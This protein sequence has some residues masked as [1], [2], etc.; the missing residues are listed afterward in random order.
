MVIWRETDRIT[1]SVSP[2]EWLDRVFRMCRIE[3]R[4]QNGAIANTSVQG[5]LERPYGRTGALD[6]ECRITARRYSFS[7]YEYVIAQNDILTRDIRLICAATIV[8][9]N[10]AAVGCRA[11]RPINPPIFERELFRRMIASGQSGDERVHLSGIRVHSDNPRAVVRSIMSVRR[12]VRVRR[13]ERTPGKTPLEPDIDRRSR[14]L[15]PASADRRLSY[16]PTN[17]PSVLIKD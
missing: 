15:K 2:R 12:L 14:W 6:A 8:Q 4:P 7:R 10:D 11:L 1:V 13:K 16:R 9:S 3:P 5:A 17:F